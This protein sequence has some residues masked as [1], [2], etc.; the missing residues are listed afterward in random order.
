MAELAPSLERTKAAVVRVLEQEARLAPKRREQAASI[1]IVRLPEESEVEW[2]P[3]SA[4]FLAALRS[5]ERRDR[6]PAAVI[7][8]HEFEAVA[9]GG[10]LR[11]YLQRALGPGRYRARWNSADSHTIDAEVV[12]I[13]DLERLARE[14]QVEADR[15]R[16][17]TV[18]RQRAARAESARARQRADEAALLGAWVRTVSFDFLTE[19]GRTAPLGL[20]TPRLQAAIEHWLRTNARWF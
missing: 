13:P 17:E 5:Q 12:E 16:A 11:T 19:V 14:R 6:P 15:R 10:G 20:E 8:R 1:T 3:D 4:S 9:L 7:P 18:R 2:H